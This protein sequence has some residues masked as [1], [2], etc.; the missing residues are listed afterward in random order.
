MFFYKTGRTGT[1]VGIACNT[2]LAHA[3]GNGARRIRL[4][5]KSRR[6]L[7]AGGDLSFCAQV[8]KLCAFHQ[9]EWRDIVARPVHRDAVPVAVEGAGI[10]LSASGAHHRDAR[11]EI[12]VGIEAGVERVKT[13][14][15]HHKGEHFPL[16]FVFY[17]NGVILVGAHHDKFL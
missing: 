9:T 5:D 1:F 6:K 12:D 14:F 2:Y 17:Q 10:F 15:V 11:A 3:L 7:V 8:H 4:G 13:N 16:V